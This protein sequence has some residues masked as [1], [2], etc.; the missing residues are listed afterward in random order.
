MKT[1]TK[2]TVTFEGDAAQFEAGLALLDE[3]TRH[4][5]ADHD[6]YQAWRVARSIVLVATGR[7]ALFPPGL[8]VVREGPAAPTV[9]DAAV[10]ADAA[11]R[12]LQA[13]L[14]ASLPEGDAALGTVDRLFA[15][16]RHDLGVGI[17][18]ATKRAAELRRAAEAE[19]EERRAA[20]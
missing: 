10:E 11:I 1:K 17:T 19:E 13:T 3:G 5:P 16:A 18:A 7:V 8:L 20:S 14:C 15:E 6:A 4:E 9:H 2:I 12:R